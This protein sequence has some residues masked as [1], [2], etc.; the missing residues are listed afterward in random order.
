M[1]TDE[2]SPSADVKAKAR[3]S[4]DSVILGIV[5]SLMNRDLDQKRILDAAFD[6]MRDAWSDAVKNLSEP[7]VE[8]FASA[9]LAEVDSLDKLRTALA[10][11]LEGKARV[12]ASPNVPEQAAV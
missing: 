11:A 8:A 9:S 1:P 3:G 7:D 5:L 12:P 10:A 4:V 2:P 6:A